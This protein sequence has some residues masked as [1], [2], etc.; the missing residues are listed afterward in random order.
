MKPDKSSG[1]CY[2]ESFW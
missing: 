1:L 2:Q